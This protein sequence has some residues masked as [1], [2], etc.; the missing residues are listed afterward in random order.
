MYF[1][2]EEKWIKTNFKTIEKDFTTCCFNDT[3][4]VRTTPMILYFM[5]PL[6]VK[7]KHLLLISILMNL[8]SNIFN[9]KK[10]IIFGSLVYA[11]FD[12]R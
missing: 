10:N 7:K 8:Q 6:E 5:F 12:T 1:D 3:F 4:L 2:L 11:L 9:M